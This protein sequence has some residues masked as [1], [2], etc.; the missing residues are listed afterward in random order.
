MAL[1]YKEYSL[2][3]N[4]VEEISESIFNSLDIFKIEKKM[5]TRVRYEIEEILM[6]IISF[7]GNDMLI[8]VGSGK[9]HGRVVVRLTYSGKS[10]NP[11]DDVDNPISDEMMKILGILPSWGYR[12]GENTVS[13][14]VK[15]REPI[16]SFYFT[17]ISISL[18]LLFGFLGRLL[19]L[20]VRENISAHILT[21]ILNI[22]LGLLTTFAGI[23]ILLTIVN[24]IQGIGDAKKLGKMGTQS[25]L[26]M[27]GICFLASSYAVIIGFIFIKYNFQESNFDFFSQFGTVTELIFDM[28]PKNIIDPFSTGN[29]IQVIVIAIIFGLV[30][31]ALGERGDKV[32]N[33]ISELTIL[34]QRIISTI[35]LFIPVFIFA[36]LTNQILIGNLNDFIS[37]LKPIGLVILAVLSIS[38]LMILIA[39]IRLKCPLGI[40][41][42]KLFSSS[43]KAFITASSMSVML[44]N[45]ET[46][47]KKLGVEKNTVSFLYPLGT[48]LYM[49][50]STT[51]ITLLSLCLV[52]MY[53]LE[54]NPLWFILAIIAVTLV[55][56][57]LPPI[58]GAGI[59]GL[60]IIFQSLGIP[61][62]GIVF[63]IIIDLILD[64]IDT[65]FNSILL[66]TR[67]TLEGKKLKCLDREI[68]LK[69]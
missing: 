29:I 6:N 8:K 61:L 38:F 52:E 33:I 18:A 54:V 55:T 57:A 30:L 21:P 50:A 7:Y 36:V 31:L 2:K 37:L 60:S 4:I 19:T 59:L 28:F 32:R 26:H 66:M 12:R 40:F 62:E 64:F 25:V 13:I 39:S 24:S 16:K 20:E 42:K 46:C 45:M 3:N 27:I 9:E 5:R 23:M 58:P 49:P 1:I 47:E 43:Y 67:I 63:A 11:V 17:L 34:F 44:P 56:M 14:I 22:F 15:D 10:F 68:L 41:I 65:G 69:K 53:N 48:V 35:C 51:Y